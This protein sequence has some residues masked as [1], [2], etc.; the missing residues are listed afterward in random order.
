MAFTPNP[1][2]IVGGQ[3][4]TVTYDSDTHQLLLSILTTLKIMNVY[5]SHIT[6]EEL[7]ESDIEEETI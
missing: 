2:V 6:G 4:E 1:Q 7:N 3:A 5:L